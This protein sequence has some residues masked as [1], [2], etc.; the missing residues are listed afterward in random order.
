MEAIEA[1]AADAL[2]RAGRSWDSLRILAVSKFRRME[3][4]EA[5]C[6]LGQKMLGE[7]RVE[8]ILRKKPLLQKSTPDLRWH[9]IGSLQRRKVKSV[10]GQVE[11]IQSLDRLSLAYEL[12]K[13]AAELGTVVSVLLQLN[14]SEEVQKHGFAPTELERAYLEI[15]TLPH[16]K[17][18]GL[19]TMAENTENQARRR[20]AFRRCRELFTLL[21]EEERRRS[22]EE[23]PFTILSMGMSG[24]FAEAIE[25]G[26]TMVRIGSRIFE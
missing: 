26:A 23:S 2:R 17:I 5:L 14:G 7:N 18:C 3:E 22:V 12:E 20:A 9:L 8:E 25:E 16:L 21:K 1:E 4:I 6:S 13:R 19:M 24:D 15:R 10:V 11:L